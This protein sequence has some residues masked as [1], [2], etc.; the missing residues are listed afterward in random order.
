MACGT[1]VAAARAGA[2]PEVCGDAAVLFEPD[3]PDSIADAVTDALRRAPELDARG[4][5]RAAGFTWERTAA[6]H[7][8]VYRAA[9]GLPVP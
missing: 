4:R 6:A 5:R 1:P 7:E 9:A 3:N 2:L 8:N